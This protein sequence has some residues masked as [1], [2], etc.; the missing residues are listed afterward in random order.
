[1]LTAA[2][3]PAVVPG[4]FDFSGFVEPQP[5][6]APREYRVG[7]AKPHIEVGFFRDYVAREGRNSLG[8]AGE[9]LALRSEQE[10]LSRSGH[11]RLAASGARFQ[12]ARR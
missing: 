8:D 3:A 1:M 4:L 5:E 2:E 12:E 7:E 6:L 11:D 10:R 9:M